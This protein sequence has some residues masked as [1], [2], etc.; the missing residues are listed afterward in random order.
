[1][2][3]CAKAVAVGCGARTSVIR[4]HFAR[5][6]AYYLHH[7]Q[8]RQFATFFFCDAAKWRVECGRWVS[9]QQLLSSFS[10]LRFVY[11][12]LD[13]VWLAPNKRILAA[14]CVCVCFFFVLVVIAAQIISYCFA[15]GSNISTWPS[16]LSS[17]WRNFASIVSTRIPFAAKAAV[18]ATQYK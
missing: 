4:T 9:E 14:H 1:M 10:C 11:S 17:S 6:N 5:A 3:F 13:S 15:R 7:R 2:R 16:L 12:T 8:Q 18:A